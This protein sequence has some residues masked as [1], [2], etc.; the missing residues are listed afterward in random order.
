MAFISVTV[1][2]NTL[3]GEEP[4]AEE[5]TNIMEQMIHK[6]PDDSLLIF[7]PSCNAW[8]IPF[9]FIIITDGKRFVKGYFR[10]TAEELANPPEKPVLNLEKAVCESIL[11]VFSTGRSY[12]VENGL[13]PSRYY[14]LLLCLPAGICRKKCSFKRSGGKNFLRSHGSGTEWKT[15]SDP[16]V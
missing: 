5:K 3:R 11:N 4:S 2:C 7:I 8:D 13:R 16:H 6:K 14:A 1:F 12:Y 9:L 10:K 15:G